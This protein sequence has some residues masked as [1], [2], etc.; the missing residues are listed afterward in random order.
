M[1]TK[2]E[3]IKKVLE[4]FNGVATLEQIYDNIEKYYP[5]AKVSIKWKAGI[6]GVINREIYKEKNFKRIGIG[7][8]ALKEYEEIP[9]PEIKDKQ[10]MHPYIEGICLEL[11]N[12][13]GYKTYTPDKTAIFKG[14]KL[15]DLSTQK[16]IPQFTY[17]EIINEVKKIDVIWF[18][19]KGLMFPQ[20]IFEIVDSANTLIDALHRSCQLL[21]FNV[22]FYIIAPMK[23]K[24]KFENKINLQP[25]VDFQQR[26]KFRD[27]NK[28]IEIHENAVKTDAID[29]EFFKSS[30]GIL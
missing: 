13:K 30:G 6:R 18:N 23:Y 11:G 15:N 20:K 28:I 22:D 16:E 8:Y 5:K 19:Q 24:E 4:E 14:I 21:N 10:R 12:L 2:V 26:Y 1:I 7:I 17:K 29:K 9:K 25:Y 3:A 27:Y